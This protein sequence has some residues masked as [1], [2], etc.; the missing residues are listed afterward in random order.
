MFLFLILNIQLMACEYGIMQANDLEIPVD[1]KS[2]HLAQ[3]QVSTIIED[4]KTVYG[5]IV[6]DQIGKEL[7]F[8][9]NWQ[10]VSVNMYATR[11]EQNNP[12][13]KIMGGMA[14]H[15]LMTTDALYSIICHEIG[16]FLGGAPKQLRGQTT[17]KSWSSAEGQ[18]DYYANARC[19]KL[20]LKSNRNKNIKSELR[21][22]SHYEE[23]NNICHQDEF[24]IRMSLASVDLAKIYDSIRPSGRKL[25]LIKKD[26]S[27]THI[28]ILN[29]PNAQC[30]LDTMIAAQLC[31]VADSLIFNDENP[32][33]GACSASGSETEAKFTRPKC[34]YPESSTPF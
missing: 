19:T 11:D 22:H 21:N 31:P 7:K 26:E 16:H 34:W 33:T 17:M 14:R 28:P 18:A 5:P 15:P 32:Q 13:V 10:D 20:M 6:K 1:V 25:S 2:T 23:A 29:H 4:F 9:L 12:I 24:C 27:Q 30:R 8:E 3:E